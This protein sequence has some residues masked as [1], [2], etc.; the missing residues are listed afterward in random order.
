M[1]VYKLGYII[2]IEDSILGVV[3]PNSMLISAEIRRV[4]GSMS[5]NLRVEEI[6]AKMVKNSQNLNMEFK[7]IKILLRAV[8]IVDSIH[9]VKE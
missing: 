6:I 7:G 4:L 9:G 2:Y 1:V 8:K 5:V 3:E